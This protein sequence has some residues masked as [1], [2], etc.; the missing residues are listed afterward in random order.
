MYHRLSSLPLRRRILLST[1]MALTIL[2]C[3]IAA[4]AAIQEK[5]RPKPPVKP[6]VTQPGKP[7]APKQTPPPAVPT[8][9]LL[10][11]QQ[12]TSFVIPLPAHNLVYDAVT[13][14][15]YAAVGGSGQGQTTNSITIID[16][17]TGAV[18]ASVFVGSGPG[19]MTLSEGSKYL[20]VAVTDGAAVRRV[21]LPALTAGPLYPMP[22]KPVKA[23]L[24]APGRPDGFIALRGNHARYDDSLGVYVN[25]K[26]Q[27][28]EA[29]SPPQVV[30]GIA[31]TR[32]F[33]YQ[34]QLSSWDFA[35][36]DVLPE[37]IQRISHTQSLMAGNIG[38]AGTLNGLVITHD[39]GVIDPET[40]QA[41]GRLNF[42]GKQGPLLADP[43]TG[44]VFCFAETREGQVIAASDARNFGFVGALPLNFGVKGGPASLLRWGDDG[45]AY[46]AGGHVIIFRMPFGP[47][48]PLNDLTVKRS[49]IPQGAPKDNKLTYQ[50]TVTHGGVA[51]ASG[52]CLSDALPPGAEVLT[53]TTSHG[54]VTAADGTVR[55]EIGKLAAGA[56]AMVRVTLQFKEM[57]DVRFTAVVR[58]HEPDPYP[59]NNIARFLPQELLAA[60][61]DL[62][63]E[64]NELR[65][66]SRGAGIY[67]ETGVV[68]RFTVR[69]A[70]NQASRPVTLR[71]YLT[72]GPVFEARSSRLIQEVNIPALQ[73]RQSYTAN[74]RALLDPGYDV[75]GL[76]IFAVLDADATLTESNRSNN[77]VG[78]RVP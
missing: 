15:I 14:K 9:P 25:G 35:G 26:L 63:G 53:M 28:T 18:G 40:R 58:A 41:V 19:V 44:Y 50:L 39:G 43:R 65:Q 21:D 1:G 54:Y 74:L 36:Y 23:L 31:P 70:G 38:L 71:F 13:R 64:W 24:P 78:N 66:V 5:G 17:K 45:F 62:T 11:P 2:L 47:L 52:V 59:E 56:K 8:P 6:P 4:E 61:P 76:Y 16:P 55:A 69:N 57:R 3:S 30:R 29:G 12:P 67:L 22:G 32:L 33:T 46:A 77:N 48:R 51:P 10:P 72:N 27:G 49:V 37:G 7:T 20:F 34:H 73:A 75:T 42:D 68:G 60:L